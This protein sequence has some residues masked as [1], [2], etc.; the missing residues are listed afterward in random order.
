MPIHSNLFIY[1]YLK[2]LL[3]YITISNDLSIYEEFNIFYDF[4]VSYLQLLPSMYIYLF[5]FHFIFYLSRDATHDD[6]VRVLKNT[7]PQV[8]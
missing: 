2:Y 1:L 4:I 8:K 5:I 7:G 3:I 6:A